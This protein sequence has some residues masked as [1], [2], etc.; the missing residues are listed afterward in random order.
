MS[1][2]DPFLWEQNWMPCPGHA[3]SQQCTNTIIFIKK[4]QVPKARAKDV[5]Y[6]LIT[7]LVQPEKIDKPNRTK[8]VTGGDKVHYPSNAGTPTA[9][10]L[11]VK[12]FIN[13]IIS[14]PG[15]KFMTL[16][17]KD[18]YLSTPMA[19]YKYMQLCIA[20]MPEDI[21][22]HHN[23]R[24]KAIPNGYIYCEIQKG[25]YGLPQAGIITQQLLKERLQKTWKPSKPDNP[26]PMEARHSAYKFL[27]GH[28]Q[29]RGKVRG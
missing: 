2:V 13:S 21:I 29:F 9:D 25:M 22:K 4:D 11:T 17:I 19:R 20:D 1:Q 6:G 3:R 5:T 12:I 27:P 26:R 10:L 8:L 18:F 24:D 7:C 28:Q 14:T 23:L 16:D 15:T